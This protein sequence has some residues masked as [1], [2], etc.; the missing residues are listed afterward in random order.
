MICQEAEMP[1]PV[2]T[3]RWDVQHQ[4]PQAF[5]RVQRAGS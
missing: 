2:E 3:P 5:H 4:A 1:Q